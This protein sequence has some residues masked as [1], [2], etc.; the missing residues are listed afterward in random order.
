MRPEE[1]TANSNFAVL[2]AI[3][4][5]GPD[6]TAAA[7]ATKAGIA[8]SAV[9]P[10]LHAWETVGLAERLLLN[11][12]TLWQL[13]DAG[14]ASTATPP[15]FVATAEPGAEQA[16]RDATPPT[17]APVDTVPQPSAATSAESTDDERDQTA[18]P[19]PVVHT[20][21]DTPASEQATADT[22]VGDAVRP[23]DAGTALAPTP[24][25][26]EAGDSGERRQIHP[27]TVEAAAAPTT[28]R[29]P[30]GALADSV[31]AIL[32]GRPDREYTISQLKRLI[33][34]MDTGVGYAAASRG[35]ISNVLDILEGGGEAVRVEDRETASF[36]IAPSAG[37][38]LR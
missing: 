36:R 20:D 22:P 33:D 28:R 5:L 2:A 14:R 9:H 38:R 24:G 3:A 35:A 37:D 10:K 30:K 13:T 34:Q 26:N 25:A 18:T 6:A 21:S 15:Q 29:R 32:R 31:L 1:P 12:K 16:V 4:D 11:G 19:V 23:F 8:L 27:G 17:I 7:I